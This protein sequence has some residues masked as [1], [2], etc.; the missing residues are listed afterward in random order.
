MGKVGKK[1]PDAFLCIQM[2]PPG[3]I[4]GERLDLLVK[5][6]HEDELSDERTVWLETTFQ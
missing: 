6:F 3:I 1:A 4:R 5:A 2:T